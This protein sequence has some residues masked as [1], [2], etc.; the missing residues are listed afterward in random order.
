MAGGGREVRG[1]DVVCGKRTMRPGRSEVQVDGKNNGRSQ[2]TAVR[3]LGGGQEDESRT[4]DIKRQE[5]FDFCHLN[6]K[7]DTL[8]LEGSSEI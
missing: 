6:Q 8:G 2:R 3:G 1:T 7:H 5:V 4:V